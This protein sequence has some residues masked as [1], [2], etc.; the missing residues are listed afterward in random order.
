M[1]IV[2]ILAISLISVTTQAAGRVYGA[3]LV[4]TTLV[5]RAPNGD[6]TAPVKDMSPIVGLG[7]LLNDTTSV[8]LDV[9]PTFMDGEYVSLTLVPSVNWNFGKYFYS[10]SRFLIMVDPFV[11]IAWLPGV[12][13]YYAFDSGLAPFAEVEM[14]MGYEGKK[15]DLSRLYS[16]LAFATGLTY[17]F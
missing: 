17:L 10:T 14:L 8:E 11:N 13:T 16:G 5:Y 12:G 1:K 6:T 4:A 7:Y 2:I 9:G 15:P 3:A